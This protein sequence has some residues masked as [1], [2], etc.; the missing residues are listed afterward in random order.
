VISGIDPTLPLANVRPLEAVAGA[1]IAARRLTLWLVAT[2]GITALFL[3]VVGI[4]GVMNQ[5]VRQ[6]THEFGVRQAL[7]ATRGDILR[8]V[9]SS[10]AILTVAGLTLGALLSVLATRLFATMLYSVR[11]SDPVTFASVTLILLVAAL[12]AAYLPA[13]RATQVNPANALRM[14]E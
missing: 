4:Y 11:P 13:R 6:R 8:L 10:G 2:F 12:A 9:L 3:A 5:A 1:A 14:T 7:G